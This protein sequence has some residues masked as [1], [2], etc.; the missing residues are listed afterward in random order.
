[1]QPITGN[2]EPKLLFVYGTLRH[3]IGSAM[4]ASEGQVVGI[5]YAQGAMYTTGHFPCVIPSEDTVFTGQ[6]LSFEHMPDGQWIDTLRRLDNYE[7]VPYLFHRV[8]VDVMLE[9]SEEPIKAQTYMFTDV[10]RVL[11]TLHPVPSGDWK[12]EMRSWATLTM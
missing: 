5:G 1:M 8:L 2:I 9:D 6:L 4:Q 3:D 7:A 10:K 11:Q 12:D